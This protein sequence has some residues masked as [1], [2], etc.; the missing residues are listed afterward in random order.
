[1]LIVGLYD[2]RTSC[3]V[4]RS[5]WLPDR[6]SSSLMVI[7]LLIAA[8]IGMLLSAVVSFVIRARWA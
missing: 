2:V 7:L 8:G 1:M 6:D 5:P 3:A 4:F